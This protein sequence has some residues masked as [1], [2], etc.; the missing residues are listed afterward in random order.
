MSFDDIIE[1]VI[2]TIPQGYSDVTYRNK[3]YG[4]TRTDFNGGKSTKIFAE[5]LGGNDVI[6]FNFYLTKSGVLLKTCEMPEQKAQIFLA[7]FE[8][9]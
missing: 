3:R 6:S 9:I 1:S 4:V 5:E 7:E 2:A 8:F